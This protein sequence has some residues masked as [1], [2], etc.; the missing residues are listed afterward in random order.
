MEITRRP[1]VGIDLKAPV[2]ARGGGDTP[3][4]RLVGDVRN[5]DVIIH[6]DGRSEAIVGVSRASGERWY[7]PIWWA[8]RGS[9]ARRA[10]VEPQWLPGLYV[11]LQDFTALA[12][13]LQM[14]EVRSRSAQLMELRQSLELRYAGQ[15]LYF[16]WIRYQDSIRT[17]QTYLAKF[18]RE[19]LSILPEVAHGVDALLAL[20]PAA[21]PNPAGIGEAV[22]GVESAA[23]RA[24]GSR[25]RQGFATDQVAKAT[26]EAYAMNAA[27]EYYE[28]R[29]QVID[30]SRTRSYDYVVTLD[31]EAW[32]VEVKGTTSKGET[33]LL[34]PR[35]VQHARDHELT[36][37]FLVSEIE[38]SQDGTGEV[39]ASGGRTAVWEPWIL[40]RGNLQ[41]VGYT[42]EPPRA[43]SRHQV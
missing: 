31:G 25:P 38:I 21:K 43:E 8:A 1:D 5:G 28:Q 11:G 36:A 6:Y 37:L 16:P 12:P 7:E 2:V 13:P 17:F 14:S 3:G 15:P 33:V 19:A 26:V 42:Y 34:T 30:T 24:G 4:Y 39:V 10:N 40:D 22:T 27:R 35:E 20:P 23:G 18:P 41:P 9:Y 32:H 29:G